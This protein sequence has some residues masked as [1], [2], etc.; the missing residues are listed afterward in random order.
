MSL[1]F[2][3]ICSTKEIAMLKYIPLSLGLLLVLLLAGC[4]DQGDP[5][6]APPPGNQVS[7]ATSIQPIFNSN[8]SCHLA[9]SP[10]L[11]MHLTSYVTLMAVPPDPNAPVNAPVV[12]PLLPDSSI[13]YKRLTGAI[14][15]RMP[16]GGPYL[17]DDLIATIGL[18]ITQGAQDN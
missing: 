14:Q 13:L 2:S 8:C 10:P 3:C 5:V 7:Y 6:V 18:W 9:A 12:I 16:Y 1:K 17:S 15:P 4:S 11:N